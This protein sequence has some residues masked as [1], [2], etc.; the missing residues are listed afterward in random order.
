MQNMKSQQASRAV[1]SI[2]IRATV[3]PTFLHA[4][5]T[6]RTIGYIV[7]AIGLCLTIAGQGLAWVGVAVLGAIA[8]ESALALHHRWRPEEQLRD[9]TVRTVMSPGFAVLNSHTTVAAV[10]KLLKSHEAPPCVLVIRDRRIAGLI[11]TEDL[12]LIPEPHWPYYNAD[13]VMQPIT[14]IN[15]V[16]VHD[17]ATDALDLMLRS[18][19]AHLQVFAR[20]R[21]VGIVRQ[22][23]IERLLRRNL[24]KIGTLSTPERLLTDKAA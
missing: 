21:F 10:A 18:K 1:R 6:L 17:S 11:V 7:T 9:L 23:E 15:A 19:R 3:G 2:T 8:A 14:Q 24:N 20:N 12:S 22:V 16:N 4:L 13:C 5:K